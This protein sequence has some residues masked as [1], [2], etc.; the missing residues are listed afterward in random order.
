MSGVKSNEGSYNLT[1][2][3]NLAATPKLIA[4]WWA[5]IGTVVHLYSILI[6]FFTPMVH[7]A[8]HLMF[9]LS[10][11]FILYKAKKTAPSEKT[12]SIAWYDFLLSIAALCVTG[13]IVLNWQS[14]A[15]RV[16]RPAQ[17]DIIFAYITILLL[18]EGTRRVMGLVLPVIA[19][20]FTAYAF[21]GFL[22]PGVFGWRG[23]SITRYAAIQFMT[24]EGIFSTPTQ[25]SSRM[26]FVFTLFGA[27]LHVSGAGEKLM[28][29]AWA[30][31]GRYTGGPGKV[32]VVASSLLAMVSG[33]ATANVATSGPFTIPM[34]K[35]M[36]FSPRLAGAIEA[37]AS[38]GGTLTP[39]VMGAG[40]FIMAEFLGVP[41]FTVMRAAILPAVLYYVCCFFVVHFESRRLGFIGLPQSELPNKLDSVKNGMLVI[42]PLV[43]LLGL[44][45]SHYPIMRAALISIVSMVV[46]S[47]FTKKNRMT[48]KK[49]FKAFADGMFGMVTLALCCAT[50]GI[51]VGC[52]A[53]SGLG[54]KFASALVLVA[55]NAGWIALI[56]AMFVA[57]ILGLG[58]PA[59][60]AYVVGAT[61]VAPA[62]IRL[63]YDPLAVH[64]FV[65]YFACLAQITPP[66]ALASFVGA[67]IAGAHPIETSF[68][69]LRLGSVSLIIPFMFIYSPT[70]LLYGSTGNILWDTFMAIIGVT[71]CAMGLAGFFMCRMS[72]PWRI[73]CFLGGL[74]MVYPGLLTD[75]IGMGLIAIVLGL[76]FLKAKKEKTPALN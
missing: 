37:V 45:F 36:G 25:V 48:L 17:T 13:Y 40:A 44:V 53:L 46:V 16:A 15:G 21:F 56:I 27:F 41:F 31:A 57:L 50:A 28:S 43:V 2:K 22:I 5:V 20:V 33:S 58:L 39:P 23:T 18:L 42:I 12:E 66:I 73:L 54:P 8:L 11:V 49:T 64:M 34:M 1:N 63:G 30:F 3:R 75:A 52:I 59:T 4:T 10:L 65:F 74:L 71:V 14:M 32:A 70:L 76:N 24:F 60:P 7:M 68:T 6:A 19:L 26:I 61:V 38:T 69:S 51:I 9:T 67:N 72:I 29:I 55:G 62:L 35:K 47:F